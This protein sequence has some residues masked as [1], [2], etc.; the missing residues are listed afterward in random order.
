MSS[1]PRSNADRTV[2]WCASLGS[3]PLRTRAIN[4]SVGRGR[5]TSARGLMCYFIAFGTLDKG[6]PASA[7]SNVAGPLN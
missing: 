4:N 3:I 5:F 1:L 6:E 2:G 7:F